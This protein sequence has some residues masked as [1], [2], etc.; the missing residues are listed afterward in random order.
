[1][2]TSLHPSCHATPAW[3]SRPWRPPRALSVDSCVRTPVSVLCHSPQG[4]FVTFYDPNQWCSARG[5][6]ATWDHVW[7]YVGRVLIDVLI[8]GHCWHLVMELKNA[9]CLAKPEWFWTTRTTPP[10]VPMVPLLRNTLVLSYLLLSFEM[11]AP[12]LVSY[13]SVT[14]DHKLGGLIQHRRILLQFWRSKV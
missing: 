13:F 8:E 10:K 9:K 6:I 4:P 3:F 11:F 14:G 5:N 7:K 1:M 2:F 12:V